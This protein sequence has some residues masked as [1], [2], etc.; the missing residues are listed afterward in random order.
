MGY[1][2]CEYLFQATP[3]KY[4]TNGRTTNDEGEKPRLGQ[5]VLRSMIR[6]IP[7][8]AI[9]FAVSGGWHDQWT[10]TNVVEVER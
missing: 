10:R 2:L 5:I 3:A 1:S 6:F 9:S 7:L 8:D 4:L